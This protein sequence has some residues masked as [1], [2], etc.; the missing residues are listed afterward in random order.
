MRVIR[1]S[2][3]LFVMFTM[4][5]DVRVPACVRA[6]Y[7]RAWSPASASGECIST[8]LDICQTVGADLEDACRCQW[9]DAPPECAC[10]CS[11]DPGSHACG[12][13]PGCVSVPE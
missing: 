8:C 12:D 2:C 11:T 10:L 7:V 13:F 9:G 4:L 6:R 1:L 3:I 5:S